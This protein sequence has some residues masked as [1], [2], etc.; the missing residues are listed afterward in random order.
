MGQRTVLAVRGRLGAVAE[1]PTATTS[2]SVVMPAHNAA[3]TIDEQL[4]AL[5]RQSFEGDLEVI[6]VGN[7][8]TDETAAIVGRHQ[9][10]FASLTYVAADQGWGCAYARNVGAEIA[11]GELLLFCDAD[12][13]VSPGWVA[14]MVA[15]LADADLVGGAL[16]PFGDAPAWAVRASILPVERLPVGFEGLRHA[17]GASMGY[18]R[19]V[20]DALGGWDERFVVG[21][22]DVAFSL[23]AQRAG[24]RLG[25]A[26]R[27]VTRYRLRE[28]VRTAAAQQRRYG[29]GRAVLA[30][31]HLPERDRGLLTDAGRTLISSAGQVLHARSVDDLR[32]AYLRLS[33]QAA[34]TAEMVRLRRGSSKRRGP[35]RPSVP[36]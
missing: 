11:R 7:H 31:H 18:R 2:V 10:H 17:V 8:C 15:A 9:R 19:A 1:D 14:G 25:F 16:V 35:R 3:L 32:V 27:A 28:T 4:R 13:V 29:R 22:D 20:H 26:D 21:G 34:R 23:E 33:F 36:R 24:F 12:D 30:W 5:S 6:V